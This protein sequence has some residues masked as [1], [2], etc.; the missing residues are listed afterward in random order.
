MIRLYKA[1]GWTKDAEAKAEME[2]LT[3]SLLVLVLC[4]SLKQ[5]LLTNLSSYCHLFC[6]RDAIRVFELSA[7]MVNE[8]SPSSIEL[9]YCDS[10]WQRG[11]KGQNHHFNAAE[12]RNV[13]ACVYELTNWVFTKL[14]FWNTPLGIW[15]LVNIDENVKEGENVLI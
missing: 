1:C 14:A 8:K 9:Q 15:V 5:V 11:N 3:R 7:C 6:Q 2:C 13:N 12:A 10:P 4:A